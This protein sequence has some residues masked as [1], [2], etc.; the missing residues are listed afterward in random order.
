MTDPT[1]ALREVLELSNK[2]RDAEESREYGSANDL[3]AELEGAAVNLVRDHGPALLSALEDAR[4]WQ[5]LAD[6]HSVAWAD[7]IDAEIEEGEG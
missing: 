6:Q 7:D 4:R 1:T 2:A 5:H 3:Y